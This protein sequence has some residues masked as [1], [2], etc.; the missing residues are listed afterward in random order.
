M[1]IPI[2]QAIKQLSRLFSHLS[3]IQ[4]RYW[5]HKDCFSEGL[6]APLIEI[7]VRSLFGSHIYLPKRVLD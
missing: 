2:S 3:Y 1:F 4:T 7:S 5:E 6:K